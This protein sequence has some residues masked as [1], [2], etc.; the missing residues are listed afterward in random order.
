MA[1]NV[2]VTDITSEGIKNSTL[3]LGVY[4]GNT[5]KNAVFVQTQ[6]L[7]D[8]LIG[9]TDYGLMTFNSENTNLNAM[10]TVTA[11]VEGHGLVSKT[12]SVQSCLDT[13]EGTELGT[14][15]GGGGGTEYTAGYGI[16]I[17]ANNEISVDENAVAVKSELVKAYLVNGPD[18]FG[19]Y[20]KFCVYDNDGEIVAEDVEL[21]IVTPSNAWNTGFVALGNVYSSVKRQPLPDIFKD[22]ESS[23]RQYY[24]N[25][26]ILIRSA[27]L[28]DY[29]PLLWGHCVID[30][31]N[32]EIVYYLFA[33]NQSVQ[34]ENIYVNCAIDCMYYN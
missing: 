19:F 29:P 26:C 24:S 30:Y 18:A 15:G 27:I 14:G 10:I 3:S 16:E 25:I 23:Y 32:E 28:E 2:L 7:T 17:S 13:V 11:D 6:S 8:N 1:K 5:S 20:K 21:N 34:V 12:L 31:E 4:D 22:F 33:A 9:I